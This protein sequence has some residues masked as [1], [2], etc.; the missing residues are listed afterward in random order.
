MNIQKIIAIIFVVIGTLGL[1][2][3]GFSYTSDVHKADLGSLHM[4]VSEHEQV[5]IP[6]SVGV[7]F[8]IV[9][10]VMLVLPKKR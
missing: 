6:I 8:I 10:G 7:T 9:G 2:Y 4:A 1:A 3:G 5:N